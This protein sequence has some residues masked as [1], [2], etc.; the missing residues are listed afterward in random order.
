MPR[1]NRHFL[2]GHLWHITHRCHEREFLLKFARDRLS[3]WEIQAPPKRYSVI[4]LSAL[5]DLCGF[6]N[7]SHFQEAHKHWVEQALKENRLERD[8][9]WS[10]AIAVGSRGFVEKIQNQLGIA[11][12]YRKIVDHNEV[13]LLREPSSSY[14][15]LFGGEKAPLRVNNA[16]PWE[17]ND[18]YSAK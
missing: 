15:P 9:Q 14:R 11:G 4:D 16:L 2:S 13:C 3:D 10:D 12:K 7:V 17:K 6:A 18:G 1:A 8:H 5:N